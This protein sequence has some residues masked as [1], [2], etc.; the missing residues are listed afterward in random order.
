[1]AEDGNPQ[2]LGVNLPGPGH[3]LIRVASGLLRLS[4]SDSLPASLPDSRDIP[5]TCQQDLEPHP[6][7]ADIPGASDLSSN[8]LRWVLPSLYQGLQQQACAQGEGR[9]RLEASTKGRENGHL[10]CPAPSA[11]WTLVFG[12]FVEAFF[13][14]HPHWSQGSPRAGPCLL[15]QAQGSLRAQGCVLP[16]QTGYPLG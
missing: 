13:C 12:R 14:P 3:P 10:D 15:P 6:S 1:M 7:P 8:G 9:D 2:C 16:H 11:L 4:L 5:V